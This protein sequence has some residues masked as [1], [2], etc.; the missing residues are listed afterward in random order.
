MQLLQRLWR[1]DRGAV[2]SIEL[3]LIG[4]VLILALIVGLA[5]FRD[6]VIQELGDSGAAIGK[7]NQ[8][9]TIEVS[10]NAPA[11]ITVA[12]DTV[13]VTKDFCFVEVVSTFQN[14]GYEDQPDV[15]ENIAAKIQYSSA[16]GADEGT[17]P[18]AFVNP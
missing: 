4:S 16:A 13:T 2:L 5:A 7:L 3:I 15:C 14:F 6:S 9:Y 18:P 8:G 12:G 1:D 10:P 11:G 17:L